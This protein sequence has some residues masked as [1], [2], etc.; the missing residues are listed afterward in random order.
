MNGV[1]QKKLNGTIRLITKT[2]HCLQW[3]GTDEAAQKLFWLQL[4]K[5][6]LEG[7]DDRD[8]EDHQ[9]LNQRNLPFVNLP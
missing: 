6:I 2:V 7:A 5:A 1:D 3:P 8:E 9:P 4:K